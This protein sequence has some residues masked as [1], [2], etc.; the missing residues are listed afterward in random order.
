[1]VYNPS[2]RHHHLA[3]QVD[4]DP[5]DA[6]TIA[7]ITTGT[8]TAG[9]ATGTAFLFD[10]SAVDGTGPIATPTLTFS[11]PQATST[12]SNAPVQS[13]NSES[14]NSSANEIPIG[15]VIGACVGAFVGAVLFI[16]IG[17]WIYKRS[18]VKHRRRSPSR[19]ARRK[20]DTWNKLDDD[21]DKWDGMNKTR[22][23]SNT[24]TVAAGA[25]T[26]AEPMEKLTMFK[27]SSPS[28]RTAYTTQTHTDEAPANFNFDHPFAQYHPNLA[29][30]LASTH[31]AEQ[32][33]VKPFVNRAEAVPSW[34]GDASVNNSFLTLRTNRLSGTMSPTLDMAIPTPPLTSS[35]SHRWE[36]AEV[37]NF[38]GQSAEIVDPSDEASR[39]N[40][41]FLHHTEIRRKSANNPFFG[42]Q[43][44]NRRPSVSKG[45]GRDITPGSVT[46]PPLENKNPFSD[47][48]ETRTHTAVNSL[49]SEASNDRAIQSLLAALEVTPE[50]ARVTSMQPSVLS[51][52]SMYTE[53]DVTAAFPIP[54]R[55]QPAMPNTNHF[56]SSS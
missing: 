9:T 33:T 25:D 8:V 38:E 4:N 13:E 23:V 6:P 41:P 10:S 1:M 54:P 26:S 39:D 18:D 15:T 42:A 52:N 56:A 11:S 55:S 20:S 37:I 35:D 17:F 27:K 7:G 48:G 28:I 29:R 47:D 14:S 16:S 44:E 12:S 46:T 19:S 34:D 49:S 36:S 53:E 21:D 50:D 2:R 40:N 45:K 24:T 43:S 32:A 51:T 3:R 30:E 22:Q 5:F 31:E